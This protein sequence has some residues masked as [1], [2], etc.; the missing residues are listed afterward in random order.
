MFSFRGA[1]EVDAG[2]RRRSWAAAPSNS[3]TESVAQGSTFATEHG[4]DVSSDARTPRRRRSSLFK[5]AKFA[6]EPDELGYCFTINTRSRNLELEIGDEL[7]MK[8]LVDGFNLLAQEVRSLER[9]RGQS[10]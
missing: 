2:L 9:G 1:S 6:P 7:L 10:P 4:S 3:A 5:R 8:R